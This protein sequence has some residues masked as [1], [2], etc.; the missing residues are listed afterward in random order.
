MVAPFFLRYAALPSPRGGILSGNE[1]TRR[2]M[3]D[4]PDFLFTARRLVTE[5]QLLGAGFQPDGTWTMAATRPPL[6]TGLADRLRVHRA[7]VVMLL[8]ED[9][10]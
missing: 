2:D 1:T 6:P 10:S 9:A 5:A 4:G 3:E 8:A 7:A